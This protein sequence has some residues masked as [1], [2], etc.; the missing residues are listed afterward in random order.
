MLAALWRPLCLTASVPL[1]LQV[2][3]GVR[4]QVLIVNGESGAGKTE[5]CRLLLDHIASASADAAVTA[6]RRTS[7]SR[8]ISSIWAN[9]ASFWLASSWL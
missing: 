6:A 3:S 7:I 5:A 2:A 8:R 4:S 9:F 1:I